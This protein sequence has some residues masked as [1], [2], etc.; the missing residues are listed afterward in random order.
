MVGSIGE[1]NGAASDYHGN[2]LI[3]LGNGKSSDVKKLALLLK[4]KV[5]ERFH[6]KLEEEIRYF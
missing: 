4:E 2:L 5:R 1:I 6:I 3:N